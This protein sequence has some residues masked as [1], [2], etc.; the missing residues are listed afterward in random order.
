MLR[1]IIRRAVLFYSVR[2]RRRKAGI[3]VALAAREGL[4]TALFVG[5]GGHGGENIG[6]FERRVTEAFNQVYACD[7]FD[8]SAIEPY[9]QADGRALPFRDDCVDLVVSNAVIEHVGGR[10]EQLAFVHEHLRVGGWWA[11]TT[12][13]RW[14][15]VES[16]TSTLLRHYAASWRAAREEHFTRLLS[17]REFRALLPSGARIIGRPWSPTFIAYGRSGQG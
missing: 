6:V 3:I 5:S 10:P 15:P 7:L 8:H 9:V 16:H 1:T 13:N 12:P 17:R 11:I 4:K 14:F 2:N